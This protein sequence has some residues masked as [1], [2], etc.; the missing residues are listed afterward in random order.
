MPSTKKNI[1]NKEATLFGKGAIID[2]PDAEAANRSKS[3]FLANMS[4]EIRAPMNSIIG[5]TDLM[6]DTKLDSEQLEY[7][8]T[9]QSSANSLLQVIND[10]LDFSRIEADKLEL[11][12][13]NFDLRTSVEE[14]SDI[15]LNP[16]SVLN[17]YIALPRY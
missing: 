11:E 9:V 15:F 13:V 17:S 3:E 2:A 7:A 5:M 1:L 4:H 12:I 10:V 14:V 6:L 16:L 8:N